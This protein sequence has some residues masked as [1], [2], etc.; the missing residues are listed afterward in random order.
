MRVSHLNDCSDLWM[1]I[2]SYWTMTSFTLWTS[3][4]LEADLICAPS[5]PRG[6]SPRICWKL[7]CFWIAVLLLLLSLGLS[8]QGQLLVIAK[9][10]RRRVRTYK[11]EDGEMVAVM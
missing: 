6:P 5:C 2:L 11:A 4:K 9:E 3:W 8:L 1:L 7:T 10:L